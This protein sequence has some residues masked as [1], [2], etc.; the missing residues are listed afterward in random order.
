MWASPNGVLSTAVLPDWLRVGDVSGD[1]RSDVVAFGGYEET[2][3]AI[4]TGTSFTRPRSWIDE[5]GSDGGWNT[6]S[7]IRTLVDVD[8][9]GRG[10]LVG[11]VSSCV[12]VWPADFCPAS[13]EF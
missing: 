8:G 13:D 9:D 5:Y 3:F 10:D 4:S 1:G 11:F 12:C 6:T 2:Y 7:H